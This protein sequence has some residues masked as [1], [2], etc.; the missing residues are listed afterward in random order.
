MAYGGVQ[1]TARKTPGMLNTGRFF[2]AVRTVCAHGASKCC[3]VTAE[4]IS[5]YQ[6]ALVSPLLPKKIEPLRETYFLTVVFQECTSVCFGY[7]LAC[8]CH[9]RKPTACNLSFA[10][11]LPTNTKRFASCTL[12][13]VLNAFQ[14]CHASSDATV[15]R[16]LYEFCRSRQVIL[17][18]RWTKYWVT[19]CWCLCSFLWQ[20][21]I[22]NIPP[23]SWDIRTKTG[24][25]GCTFNLVSLLRERAWCETGV[26]CLDTAIVTEQ[27]CVGW[28]KL[29]HM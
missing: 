3:W 9:A 10:N 23:F 18:K 20:A 15:S 13:T 17:R 8:L 29:T 21:T 12:C 22:G 7:F 19:L 24:R 27:L 6:C 26:L 16:P 1:V 14:R 4:L 28:P 5:A 11:M 25:G 2:I